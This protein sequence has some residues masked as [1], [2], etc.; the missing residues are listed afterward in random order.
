MADRDRARRSRGDST[1]FGI[2]QGNVSNLFAFFGPIL[3]SPTAGT[4]ANTSTANATVSTNTGNGTL[5]WAV[6][7][8]GGAA[9]TAQIKAGSGGNIISAGSQAVSGTGTQTIASMTG[10]SS[11]TNYQIVYVHTNSSSINSAQSQIPLRT[12]SGTTDPNWAN[13]TALW[14]NE[15]GSN[16]SQVF[17][18][19]STSNTTLTS[20]G[21]GFAWSTTSPPTGLTSSAHPTGGKLDT[22]STLALSPGTG[23]FTAE[24]YIKCT[25]TGTFFGFASGVSWEIYMNG[26][27]VVINKV[28][29]VSQLMGNARG[30]IADGG[31]HHLAW[32]RSGTTNTLYYDGTAQA[33]TA[34]DSTNYNSNSVFTVAQ[35]PD[36]TFQGYIASF[37]FTTV[38]RYTANFTPPTL[39]LPN[40]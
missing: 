34:T 7:T 22:A 21:A 12:T 10:L 1:P 18:D 26:T 11:G 39:P 6:V 23:D 35:G 8:D 38:A 31:W 16:A 37:R 14:F 3:S 20:N 9:T 17:I 32:V 36:G 25:T 40:G 24:C 30:V 4:P 13:V 15:N 33:T 5:Y 19:Q 28:S 27:N 29:G 2:K